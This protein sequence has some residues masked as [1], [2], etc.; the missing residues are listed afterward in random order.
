MPLGDVAI[1]RVFDDR[2]DLGI[3]DRRDLLTD[4]GGGDRHHG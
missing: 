2:S 3:R 1:D 4:F